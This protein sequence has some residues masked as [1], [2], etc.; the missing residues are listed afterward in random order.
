LLDE[1]NMTEEQQ[2]KEIE[3]QFRIMYEGDPDL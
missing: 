3:E 1:H 2:H